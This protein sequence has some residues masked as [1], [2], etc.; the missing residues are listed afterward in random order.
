M[1]RGNQREKAR[2]KNLKKQSKQPKKKEDGNAFKKRAESDAEIMRQ[3]QQKA[4]E[5]KAL[6]SKAEKET[7][8]SK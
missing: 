8:Q 6:E 2:E 3:K 1:A 4:L 7:N 5:L